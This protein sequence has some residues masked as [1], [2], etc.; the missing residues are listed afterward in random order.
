M[1]D[2]ELES[3]AD[4]INA[5]GMFG[6]RSSADKPIVEVSTAVEWAQSVKAAFGIDVTGIGVGSDP[7]DCVGT[8][9]GKPFSIELAELL[10][11]EVQ[12]MKARALKSKEP[13]GLFTP[14]LWSRELL[15]QNIEELLDKK[16]T[17]YGRRSV[18]ADTLVIHSDEQWL[19]AS[20][21]KLWL[22]GLTFEP[23]PNVRSAYLLLTYQPQYVTPHW[24]IFR[25]Y[26]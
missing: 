9:D 10:K 13:V 21:A 1:S 4:A 7:P 12:A 25:L 11:G 26:G 18:I 23:R 24:P 17:R 5:R 15:F 19:Q 6:R 2:D 3:W 20:D 16:Q 8:K 22:V 14:G